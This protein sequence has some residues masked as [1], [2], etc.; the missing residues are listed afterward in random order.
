[1]RHMLCAAT[2]AALTL[3]AIA[4]SQSAEDVLAA[5]QGYMKLI[6]L[7]T[8][9]LSGMARGN[10]DYDED[11]AAAAAANL[12]ALVRYDAP[13]LF[14]PETSSDDLANSGA[15]PAIWD[16]PEDFGAKFAALGDAVAGSTDAVRGGQ[17]NVGAALQQIGGACKDCH[18]DYRKPE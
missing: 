7:N 9:V 8:G 1:M 6:G 11:R 2:L 10:I 17:G 18:D 16:N 13:G 15:L 5:R 3:P 4:H 14:V 12:E